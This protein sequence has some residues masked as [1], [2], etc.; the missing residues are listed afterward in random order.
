MKRIIKW[1]RGYNYKLKYRWWDRIA[2]GFLNLVFFGSGIVV[3]CNRSENGIVIAYGVLC[4]FSG[5]M[6]ALYEISICKR[7]IRELMKAQNTE[8]SNLEE[9][10]H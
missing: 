8:Q 4:L 5:F 1:L 6:S 7:R 3:I 9:G 2:L 10:Y